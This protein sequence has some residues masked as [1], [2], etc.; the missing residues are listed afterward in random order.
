MSVS[1][2]SQLLPPPTFDGKREHYE[3]WAFK[4]KSFLAVMDADFLR[5]LAAVE[6]NCDNVIDDTAF[7]SSTTGLVI[8][9]LRDRAM[10]LQWTLVATCSGSAATVL[11]R[12]PSDPTANGFESWR[13]LYNK[14]KV[15]SRARAMGR[16]SSIIAPNFTSSSFED[17]LQ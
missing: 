17:A 6:L 10:T 16:L 9:G 3:E 2:T 15:P 4:M 14:Y 5:D 1:F 8:Q 7:T 12:D 13:L 11:R